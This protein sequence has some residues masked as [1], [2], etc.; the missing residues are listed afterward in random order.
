MNYA[1]FTNL[2]ASISFPVYS[3]DVDDGN[4]V[5]ASDSAPCQSSQ[6]MA[7]AEVTA[8]FSRRHNVQPSIQAGDRSRHNEPTPIRSKMQRIIGLSNIQGPSPATVASYRPMYEALEVQ[9]LA[10]VR[11][12]AADF[13]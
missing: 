12:H 10:L 6:A 2:P 1:S 7:C 11:E 13:Q 3:V 9:P 4:A 5:S 8:S